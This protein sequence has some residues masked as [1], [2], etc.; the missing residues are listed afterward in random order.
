[1]E[2][3]SI[4]RQR[5][6]YLLSL[7]RLTEDG[8][9][10][11]IG[12]KEAR[13]KEF[14][15]ELKAGKFKRSSLERIDKIFGKGLSFYTDPAP[16]PKGAG[17]SAH[18]IFFRK[19]SFNA[20]LGL[21]DYRFVSDT[22]DTIAEIRTLA[23]L[24]GL[25]IR[26]SIEEFHHRTHSAE[27]IA[28]KMRQV[29][30]PHEDGGSSRRKQE[31]R[32][33]LKDLIDRISEVGVLVLEYPGNAYNTLEENRCHLSGLFIKG[34]GSNIAL[35]REE[36]YH[37]REIFTLAHELGHCLI[38]SEEIDA[39]PFEQIANREIEGWCNTFAFH[40]L[41]SDE[42]RRQLLSLREEDV[43]LDNPL[44]ARISGD[45]HVSRLAIYTHLLYEGI[46]RDDQYGG[47]K[48][49]LGR[50]HKQRLEKKR[51]AQREE[52]ARLQEQ[53]KKPGGAAAQPIRSGLEADVYRAAYHE[54]LVEGH[55]IARR[56][57][58]RSL[59]EF[60]YA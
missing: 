12:Y 16:L 48:G 44:I 35:R 34:C 55:E 39:S 17:R 26:R 41:T 5:L 2:Q 31:D 25:P 1:M 27:A 7:F 45:A 6:E 40:F 28:Q 23:S 24:S 13:T 53:G 11:R 14:R 58:P 30:H 20:K 21:P 54:G 36:D 46:I 59:D 15:E 29:L 33:F 49:V 22:E 32:A 50:S 4:N 47:L 60:L 56:F 51:Q 37:K 19:D 43:T 18:S 38:G 10:A 8:L 9:V 42:Q 52:R 57:R 3:I